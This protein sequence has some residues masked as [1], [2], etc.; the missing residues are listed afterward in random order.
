MLIYANPYSSP[1]LIIEFCVWVM[2]FESIQTNKQTNI[3]ITSS[4]T[5][6]LPGNPF[7]SLQHVSLAPCEC[8]MWVSIK[9]CWVWTHI[10]ALISPHISYPFVNKISFLLFVTNEMFIRLAWHLSWHGT[11][12]W[13]FDACLWQLSSSILS[14]IMSL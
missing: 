5:C 2:N 6:R 4:D 12:I 3:A 9:M 8:Y 14:S 13:T 7:I 1:M 10:P 11:W